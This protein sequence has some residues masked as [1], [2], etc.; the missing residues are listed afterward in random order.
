MSVAAIAGSASAHPVHEVVQNAYLTLTPGVARLQIELTAGPGV[1]GAIVRTIDINHD[2]RVSSPEAQTYASAVLRRSALTIDGR[3][4]ALRVISVSVPPVPAVLGAHGTIVI[5]AAASRA[6]RAGSATLVYRN[7]YAPAESRCDAN[8]FLKPAARVRYRV[9][10]Q[11]HLQAGR[12]LIAR[13]RT[14]ISA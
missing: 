4:A 6:D 9:L 7:G 10:A 11:R 5:V 12:V 2:G 14:D 3:P 8:I 13:Y 1:A